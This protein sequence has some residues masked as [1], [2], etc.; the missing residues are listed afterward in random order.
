MTISLADAKHIFRAKK[1]LIDIHPWAHKPTRDGKAV[2]CVFASRIKIDGTMPRGI[3]FRCTMFPKYP[4]TAAIQIECEILGS[5]SHIP[6]YRLDWRP[7]DTH[8]NADYGPKILRGEFFD[9][10]TTHEH[11]F[12]YHA[13]P[14]MKR[15]RTG[16]VQTARKIEPDFATFKDTLAHSCATLRMENWVDVP[17]PNLQGEL[18]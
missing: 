13:I 14:K 16:G 17:P 18:L 3:W 8:T 12:I 10:G 2:Q 6:L 5:R 7:I 11:V 1:R 4:D 9:F 15:L